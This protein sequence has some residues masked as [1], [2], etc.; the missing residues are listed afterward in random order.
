MTNRQDMPPNAGAVLPTTFLNALVRQL[1]S[2]LPSS[3]EKRGDDKLDQAC[4]L[5]NEFKSVLAENDLRIIEDKIT[6]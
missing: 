6:L 5:T 2:R 3:Q 4:E 1:P